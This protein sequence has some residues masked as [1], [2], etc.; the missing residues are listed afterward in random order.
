MIILK[1]G[2]HMQ[3]FYYIFLFLNNEDTVLYQT[4]PE[5]NDA[6]EKFHALPKTHNCIYMYLELIYLNK[7]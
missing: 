3:S 6:E 7:T 5:L 1:T 2:K 4:M